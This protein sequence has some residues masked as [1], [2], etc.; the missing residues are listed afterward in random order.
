MTTRDTWVLS[1]WPPDADYG[2]RPFQ[3]VVILL[4][5]EN[6]DNQKWFLYVIDIK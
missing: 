3:I 6:N 5:C 2:E 4:S 1:V